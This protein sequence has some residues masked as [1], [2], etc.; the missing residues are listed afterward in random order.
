LK[1][2]GQKGYYRNRFFL[3][4]ASSYLTGNRQVYLTQESIGTPR[5]TGSIVVLLATT[6]IM[7]FGF[8]MM[9]PLLA[10]H[11]TDDLMLGATIAG[12]VLAVRQ[13]VQFG[14]FRTG[15]VIA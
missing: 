5:H 1:H 9:M 13:F 12:V 2:L 4:R 11:I 10:V 6:G 14:L 8:F 15:P 7:W 3:N